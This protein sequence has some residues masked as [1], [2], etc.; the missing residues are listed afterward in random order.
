MQLFPLIEGVAAIVPQSGRLRD[1]LEAVR[2]LREAGYAVAYLEGEEALSESDSR[3]LLHAG[4]TVYPKMGDFKEN[5]VTA[6]IFLAVKDESKYNVFSAPKHAKI[7]TGL[8]DLRH[9][10]HSNMMHSAV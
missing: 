1:E 6:L 7:V 2:Y 8:R 10:L 4:A 5:A 9:L 3:T